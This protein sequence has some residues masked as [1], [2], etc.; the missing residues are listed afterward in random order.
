[1]TKGTSHLGIKKR[2]LRRCLAKVNSCAKELRLKAA[3]HPEIVRLLE[4]SP[5]YGLL[6]LAGGTTLP[7]LQQASEACPQGMS[8]NI[9]DRVLYIRVLFWQIA[10]FSASRSLAQAQDFILA[11]HFRREKVAA[12]DFAFC[13]PAEGSAS[14]QLAR[15]RKGSL[16]CAG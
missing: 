11:R 5:N 1:M 9:G 14:L 8:V 10:A 13:V 3:G 15:Q 12:A 16:F 2:K 6:L 7:Y 4:I